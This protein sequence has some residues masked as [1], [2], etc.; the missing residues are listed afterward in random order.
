MKKN[1]KKL[2]AGILFGMCYEWVGQADEILKTKYDK[3]SKKKKEKENY[4]QFC[5]RAFIDT[6]AVLEDNDLV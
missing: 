1:E 2:N 5:I 6:L 3:L 4:T